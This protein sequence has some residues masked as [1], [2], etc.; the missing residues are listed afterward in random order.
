MNTIQRMFKGKSDLQ[1]IRAVLAETYNHGL[2][3]GQLGIGDAEHD[4]VRGRFRDL[5]A[6]LG[7]KFDEQGNII[8][9]GGDSSEDEAIHQQGA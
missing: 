6:L 5:V 3:H 2:T 4:A 9:T 7:L 1:K 8:R